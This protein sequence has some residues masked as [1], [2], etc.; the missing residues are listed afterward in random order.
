M[1]VLIRAVAKKGNSMTPLDESEGWWGREGWK[2]TSSGGPSTMRP[3]EST[4]DSLNGRLPDQPTES[5]SVADVIPM[6]SGGRDGEI[7][8][9]ASAGQQGK[10]KVPKTV[11][12]N[13]IRRLHH[14]A[15]VV[16]PNTTWIGKPPQL[17]GEQQ[18][19]HPGEM[20]FYDHALRYARNNPKAT[21]P[22]VVCAG[23]KEL[24]H[25]HRRRRRPPRRDPE[26]V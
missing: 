21:L 23:K 5:G 9:I 3:C 20:H 25:R 11:S 26:G 6:A 13:K 24:Q 10:S 19:H 2:G 17:D 22:E 1:D 16:A 18:D 4:V 8:K 15:S 14:N 12:P 7:A